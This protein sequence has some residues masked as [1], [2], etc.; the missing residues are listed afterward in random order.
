MTPAITPSNTSA[1]PQRYPYILRVTRD[2]MTKVSDI[3]LGRGRTDGLLS[4]GLMANSER[5]KSRKNV[6]S[7]MPQRPGSGAVNN[8]LPL[9]TYLN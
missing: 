7:G 9:T 8:L 5:Q 1:V 6:N 3:Y 4:W 2:T